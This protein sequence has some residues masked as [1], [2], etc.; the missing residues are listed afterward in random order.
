[1]IKQSDQLCEPYLEASE[2]MLPYG[3]G[4]PEVAEY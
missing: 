2:A 3:V 1:M 4:M